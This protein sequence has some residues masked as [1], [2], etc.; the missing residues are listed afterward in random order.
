[1]EV[2]QVLAAHPQVAD[3]ALVGLSDPYLGEIPAAVVQAREKL[4]TDALH[5]FAA[6]RLAPFKLPVRLL[7]SE[8]PL[9]RNEGGKLM[10]DRLKAMF[11]P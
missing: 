4:D 3:A 7:V 6:E 8:A 2:E 11:T 5:A 10:K 1:V 9:P